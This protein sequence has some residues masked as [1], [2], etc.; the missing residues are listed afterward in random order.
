MSDST[1]TLPPKL[2]VYVDELG[3]LEHKSDRYLLL[4]D[5]GK[6]LG[7]YPAEGKLDTYLVPGCVSRVWLDAQHRDGVMHYRAAAEGQ[8]AQGM[9]AMLVNGLNEETPDAVLAVDPGF[10]R[11]AGL[12]ES[13]TAARQ[14]GLSSMLK[15][16]QDAARRYADS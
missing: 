1:T 12:S 7:D 2:K 11:D 16:M 14:G 6:E 9:V 10:I 5:Y 4:L 13:L 8:I 15:R 3:S